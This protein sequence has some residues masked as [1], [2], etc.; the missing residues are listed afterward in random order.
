[1][2]R[3]LS[4]SHHHQIRL[5]LLVILC[6]LVY[7]IYLFSVPNFITSFKIELRHSY[8]SLVGHTDSTDGSEKHTPLQRNASPKYKFLRDE[9]L[10]ASRH[11]P[12]ALIIGVKKSGTRALLEFIKLHPNVQAPSSEMHFFDKNYVRGLS[13]YRNQMPLTLEGQMTMEKTPSYFVTKR[14]PSRVKKMNPYVKLIVVDFLGLKVII[15]EK[16]FYFNTTKGFPCLM[17]SETLASPHCLGKNKGR[18]HPKIDESI[19]DR[20]TQFYRPFNLKF[21]QMTGIDFGW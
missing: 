3:K 8:G 12:D 6:S 7:I 10:Q 17:K 20:L 9:N 11:L 18:I 21:Y 2:G 16:H 13:W 19:L 14:V 5:F 1:M 4:F 15:T